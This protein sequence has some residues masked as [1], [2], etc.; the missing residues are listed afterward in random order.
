MFV[1]AVCAFARYKIAK[2]SNVTKC[3]QDCFGG[4]CDLKCSAKECEVSCFGGGCTTS[5]SSS[6]DSST[7]AVR[8][9]FGITSVLL[10]SF[11]IFGT[12]L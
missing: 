7:S 3:E 9:G 6:S 12:L 11:S 10:C 2:L 1:T 4:G 5:D 8:N